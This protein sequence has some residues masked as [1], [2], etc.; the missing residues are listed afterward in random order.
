M[1]TQ[2]VY[3]SSFNKFADF[4]L[5][6]GYPNPR[7][8]RHYEL[9][10]VLV[11]YSQSISVTSTVSLQTAEMRGLLLLATVRPTKAATERS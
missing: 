2:T 9:P 7:K 5:A 11:A 6:N 4:C 3:E 1:A 8:E 10:A